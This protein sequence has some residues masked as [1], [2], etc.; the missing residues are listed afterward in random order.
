VLTG[1]LLFISGGWQQ[2]G[3]FNPETDIPHMNTAMRLL[4]KA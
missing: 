3:N 2:I 1:Q 4:E